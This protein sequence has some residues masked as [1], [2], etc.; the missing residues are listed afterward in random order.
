MGIRP[1]YVWLEVFT[2]FSEIAI[3]RKTIDNVRLPPYEIAAYS[4]F[5]EH[6]S[7]LHDIS[8]ICHQVH[9]STPPDPDRPPIIQLN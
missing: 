8:I 2:N 9:N 5:K 6:F 4:V 3:I 1:T 7:C